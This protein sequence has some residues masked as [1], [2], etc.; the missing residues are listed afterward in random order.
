MC[1]G[2]KAKKIEKESVKPVFPDNNN[3]ASSGANPN[4]SALKSKVKID[5]YL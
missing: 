3:I 5:S 1:C 4:A 2:N